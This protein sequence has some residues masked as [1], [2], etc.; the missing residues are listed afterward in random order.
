MGNGG[1]AWNLP[2]LDREIG[3]DAHRGRT[4]G[5]VEVR[6]PRLDREEA[7]RVAETVRSA[8]LEAREARSTREA[9]AA[10]SRAAL[11]LAE[12]DGEVGRRAVALLREELGWTEGLARE[13]LAGMAEGW[14]EGALTDLL[15]R[16]LGG[17]D[18][19]DGFVDAPEPSSPGTA[20]AGSG[21][22]GGSPPGDADPSAGRRRRAVG[23]PLLFV[24]HA[25]NVPGVAV[26]AAL[27]GLLVR[28]G[29]L[30]KAP[31]AE[32]GLLAL[33]ARELAREDPLLGR[34]LATT[35][36]PGGGEV[37]VEEEWA[38]RAGTAVVYGGGHAVRALRRK[39]PAG[40]D[41][42]VHGPK[43]GVGAV[44]PDVAGGAAGPLREAAAGL[45]RDVCAYGQAGCVSPRVVYVVGH[46]AGPFAEALGAALEEETGRRPP[47]P[48]ARE[49][50]VALRALRARAEFRGYADDPD[51]GGAS[52]AD[53]PERL[54]GSREGLDWTVLVGGDPAPL[55]EGLPRVVRL[56]AVPSLR[57][58]EAILGPAVGRLQTLGYAGREGRERLAAAAVRLGVCRLAPFGSVAWPP[59]DWRHDGRHQLLPLVRWTEL[60]G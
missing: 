38:R 19:V 14:R 57:T 23:P 56:H 10:A 58:L 7:G 43:L 50:A 48:P 1:P 4:P 28:S 44:L 24:V 36:W 31:E 52:G 32:P 59:P 22:R 45:A 11:R 8:A 34:S 17:P 55:S 51:V 16:E 46:S 33:F 54:L 37:P 18:V 47:P 29:V 60:E 41:L 39:L 3:R 25:G 15:D 40:A 20:A 42:V 35:W 12:P 9:V 30:C 2:G 49:E 27:R 53:V 13:T 6:A 26:T 5:G 21:A